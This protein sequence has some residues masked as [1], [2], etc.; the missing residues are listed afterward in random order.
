MTMPTIVRAPGRSP[1]S[2]A[3]TTGMITAQT[4]VVGATMAMVPMASARYSRATP[5]LPV[6]PAASPHQ[7]SADAGGDDCARRGIS[8]A[9]TIRPDAWLTATTAT[10]AARFDARPP[11]KSA[12]P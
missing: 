7:R 12:A 8:T 1:P 10:V 9:R 6:N 2:T 4:A 11:R 5:M 3:A